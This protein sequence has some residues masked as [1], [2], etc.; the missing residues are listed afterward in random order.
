[1][2][3]LIPVEGHPHLVRDVE[4][5]AIINTNSDAIALARLKKQQKLEKKKQQKH[6]ESRITNLESDIKDIKNLLE[7]LVSKNI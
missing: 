1:M 7:S 6:L 5:N 4:T 3:R 2:S